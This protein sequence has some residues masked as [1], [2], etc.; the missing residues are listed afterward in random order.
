MVKIS[1]GKE[2]SLRK[3]EGCSER[4][5][6]KRTTESLEGT[7]RSRDREAWSTH[8]KKSGKAKDKAKDNTSYDHND[9]ETSL[10]R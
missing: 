9:S 8:P 1:Q 5:G 3:G 10:L 7:E 6:E 2:C 4:A